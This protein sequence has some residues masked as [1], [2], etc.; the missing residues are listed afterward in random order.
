MSILNMRSVCIGILATITMDILSV[1]ALKLGLI[2]AQEYQAELHLLHVL[3]P[4][5][6]GAAA[7]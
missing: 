5:P 4:L 3:P 6:H 2:I 1:M 7:A